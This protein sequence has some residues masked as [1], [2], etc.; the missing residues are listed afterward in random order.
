[1]PDRVAYL[2]GLILAAVVFWAIGSGVILTGALRFL[3]STYRRVDAFLPP[4]MAAPIDPN[5]TGSPQSLISWDSLGA[6]GR[7]RVVAAPTRAD[8]EA[9]TGG[10][11]ME[12]LRIYVGANSADTAEDRAALALAELI[13]TGAFDRSV[14][15]IATPTGTGWVDPSGMTPVEF[16]HRGDIASV[17]VQYSYLPS[18]LSLLVEPEYGHETAEAVFR[19]VYGHWRKLPARFA[20]PA[21]SLRT[22]SRFAEFRSGGRLLRHRGRTLPRRA[23]GRPAICQPHMEQGHGRTRAWHAG[24]GCPDSATARCSA[25]PAR[26]IISTFPAQAGDRCGWS[27]CSTHPIPSPSSRKA[28]FGGLRPG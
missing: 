17:S 25:S 5:K 6:Q 12:P 8:I 19:T 7:N 14:L 13:R 27:I 9:L 24:A 22:E 18:W 21:L 23:V 4:E 20:A 15:V 16:L 11:A 28:V 10:P 3:D 1:M 2:A 26:P